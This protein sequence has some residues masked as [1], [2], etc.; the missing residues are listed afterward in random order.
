[1]HTPEVICPYCGKPAVKALGSDIYMGRPE[2]AHKQYW[3]C[4]SCDAWVGCHPNTDYKPLGRL[5]D[6]A[7]RKAKT[8]VHAV[9]DT[10]WKN[11]GYKQ[12]RINRGKAYADLA[13]KLDLPIEQ[14]H[15]GMFDLETCERAIKAC[16]ELKEQQ[17]LKQRTIAV[18]ANRRPRRR[19]P[20]WQ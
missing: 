6:P 20:S 8:A 1:M 4:W 5:A 10:L 11:S 9:F 14:C 15:I 17:G 13:A 18:S 7:L 3:A 19:S 2:L 16:H 12:K